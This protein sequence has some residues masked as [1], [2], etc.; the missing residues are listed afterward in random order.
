MNDLKKQIKENKIDHFIYLCGEETYLVDFYAKT[1]I[2]KILSEEEKEYNFHK[3]NSSE[4]TVDILEEFVD[5]ISFF[6]NKKLIYIL[7]NK[8]P[9]KIEDYLAEII[10]NLDE[11]TYILIKGDK[12]DKRK[13]FYKSIGKNGTYA[14]FQFLGENELIKFIAR[15]LSKYELSIRPATA[16]YF[17]EYVG[18]KLSNI[19]NELNK[20]ISFVNGKE[21]MKKHIDS[22]CTRSVESSVFKLVDTFGRSDL[23]MALSIY[24][25]LIYMKV[26][27]QMVL[28][29]INRQFDILYQTKKLL[30]NGY[31]LREISS[32]LGMKDFIIEKA[33]RQGK[34]MEL[35]D[36]KDNFERSVKITGLIREGVYNDYDGVKQLIIE[37]SS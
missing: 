35:S 23:K 22:V 27:P 32:Y 1:L 16:S 20:L 7:G 30:N 33:F 37:L 17:I 9:N 12:L 28:S 29:M 5:T 15:E 11:M 8:L 19:V 10:N 13:K 4:V 31:A 2:D 26:Q 6:N 24:E 21:V 36:I 34:D 25:D 14:E 3:F 18:G